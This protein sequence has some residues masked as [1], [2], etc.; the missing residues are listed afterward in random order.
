MGDV[1][2]SRAACGTPQERISHIASFC[3]RLRSRGG[4]WLAGLTLTA[5]RVFGAYRP[6]C[7]S[8]VVVVGDSR[9]PQAVH[10]RVGYCFCFFAGSR[11][12]QGGW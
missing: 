6:H 2:L 10:V 4:G 5:G 12:E 8:S 7:F 9:K 3:A 11:R 1:L